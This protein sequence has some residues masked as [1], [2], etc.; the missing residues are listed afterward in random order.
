MVAQMCLAHDV[1]TL[2]H[3][4]VGPDGSPMGH[5]RSYI[6]R[7]PVRL[8]EARGHIADSTWKRFFQFAGRKG[9]RFP[10]LDEPELKGLWLIPCTSGSVRLRQVLF[11]GRGLLA[12]YRRWR[13]RCLLDSVRCAYRRTWRRILWWLR[14]V[15]LMMWLPFITRVWAQHGAFSVVYPASPSAL[16]GGSGSHGRQHVEAVL[17]VCGSSG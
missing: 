6:R 12:V 16:G 4:G 1:V 11:L 10:S 9:S 13:F 17:S 7:L 14:C 8:E 15:W 5:F 3:S 2:H